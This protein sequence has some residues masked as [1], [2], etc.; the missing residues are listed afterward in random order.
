MCRENVVQYFAWQIPQMHPPKKTK[1]NKQTMMLGEI[2]PSVHHVG[3]QKMAS[4]GI[5]VGSL[6]L[7]FRGLNRL[8]TIIAGLLQWVRYEAVIFSRG[9]DIRAVFFVGM[10]GGNRQEMLGD[11]YFRPTASRYSSHWKHAH[12][13][14]PKAL[15]E[16]EY[17]YNDIGCDYT[18]ITIKSPVVQLNHHW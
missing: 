5:P 1:K 17:R 14:T 15:L 9:W 2:P 11:S 10:P 4:Y 6:R 8:R 7:V 3:S 18:S 13:S 16:P 12:S